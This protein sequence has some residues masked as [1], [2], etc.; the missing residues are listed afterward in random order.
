[1]AR[2]GNVITVLNAA[3]HQISCN[4]CVSFHS[5]NQG[6]TGPVHTLPTQFQ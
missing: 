3:V 1:M 2:P 5:E 6:L 4:E